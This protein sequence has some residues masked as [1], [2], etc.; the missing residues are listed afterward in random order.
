[1]SRIITLP[2]FKIYHITRD[3]KIYLP[4]T[5]IGDVV[6]VPC[7]KDPLYGKDC[8]F[9]DESYKAT[10]VGTTVILQD[11]ARQ[12][13]EVMVVFQRKIKVSDKEFVKLFFLGER[14]GKRII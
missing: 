13:E 3:K 11:S 2:C 6:V 5:P 9:A 12:T 4:W 8:L 10:T 7:G 14:H 1:M